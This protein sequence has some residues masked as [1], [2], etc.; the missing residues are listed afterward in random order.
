MMQ[1]ERGDHEDTA[2][3]RSARPGQSSPGGLAG[4]L[5][6]CGPPVSSDTCGLDHNDDDDVADRDL[7]LSRA[8]G[9]MR[10]AEW[11][12]R[13]RR[14]RHLLLTLQS[15]PRVQIIA[16]ALG[17]ALALS[18]CAGTQQGVPKDTGILSPPDVSV[19]AG[20]HGAIESTNGNALAAYSTGSNEVAVVPG[21]R[22]TAECISSYWT[23]A[24]SPPP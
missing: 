13:G 4:R 5:P 18:G 3:R 8:V 24:T 7:L 22:S 23:I 1:K 16:P 9:P 10:Q 14:R 20:L 15:D 21:V 19:A 11:T 17:L 6:P 2:T 12:A